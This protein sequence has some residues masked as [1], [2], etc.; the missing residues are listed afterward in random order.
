[1]A[2]AQFQIQLK[3]HQ[4]QGGFHRRQTNVHERGGD[5]KTPVRWEP[6]RRC[7]PTSIH[8]K[9]GSGPASIH[10]PRLRPRWCGRRSPVCPHQRAAP[11]GSAKLGLSSLGGLHLLLQELWIDT[12][13]WSGQ[14]SSALAEE[15]DFRGCEG[16]WRNDLVRRYFILDP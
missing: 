13:D 16:G 1:M 10:A 2:R 9:T 14:L 7:G 15:C 8:P 4:S 12:L 6:S 11:P 5:G 3:T